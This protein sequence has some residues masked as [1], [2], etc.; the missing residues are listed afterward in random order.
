VHDVEAF[1]VT[2]PKSRKRWLI[3]L[4]QFFRF[5][6]SQKIILTDPSAA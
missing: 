2:V 5:A 6:R 3:V 4:R 1:L